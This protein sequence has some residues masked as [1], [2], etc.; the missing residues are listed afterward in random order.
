MRGAFTRF[1][2]EGRFTA[3]AKNLK[4]I[5]D[6]TSYWDHFPKEKR[7]N[8]IMSFVEG[9]NVPQQTGPLGDC[10][11]FLCMFM[12]KL[13][14][15]LPLTLDR[16][17]QQAAV[18]FSTFSPT[19]QYLFT[20]SI[21]MANNPP[22]F[23]PPKMSSSSSSMNGFCSCK[24]EHCYLCDNHDPF[25]EAPLSP[26]SPTMPD[27]VYEQMLCAEE[28]QVRDA[29]KSRHYRLRYEELCKV[30]I[31]KT[32]EVSQTKA[33]VKEVQLH[34]KAAEKWLDEKDAE[35]DRLL[36][37]SYAL[38]NDIRIRDNYITEEKLKYP[39]QFPDNK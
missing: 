4:K 10:G 15:G 23:S 36:T 21:N 12:E 3:F 30:V 32:K 37:K 1:G 33:R 18:A 38:E 39:M 29:E 2:E 20:T 35:M 9:E 17:A 28:R 22:I 11:I 27:F 34:V 24:Q 31:Q 16:D 7:R 13:A 8:G 25:P 5:I 19:P 26:T 14:S 6:T